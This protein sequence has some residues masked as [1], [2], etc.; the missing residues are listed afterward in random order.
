VTARRWPARLALVTIGLLGAFLAGEALVRMLAPQP[1]RPA[2]SDEVDGIR[3]A[4]PSVRG[5]HAH[6][7]AFDV[8]V[9]I[10][11]QRLR[12]RR[13]YSARPPEGTT[14]LAVLGDSMAF[15][16]G[17]EDDETYP[18]RLEGILARR[19]AVEVVN[20]GFP[21]TCLGEKVG[22]YQAGVR[23]LRPRVVLLTLLGDDV[24]GDL[25][26][27]VFRLENGGLVRSRRS[28]PA[29]TRAR[30]TAAALSR[31]PG[32]RL[33]AEHSQLFM[34]VRRGLT[35][36]LSR[37]RTTALGQ[38]PATAEEARRFREEGIPLLRAELRHLQE[39]LRADGAA[40]A[41]VFVPFRQEVYP[42]PADWW[43]EE[44]R[45]KSRAI[46]EAA[47]GT[48]AAIGAP[49]LDLAPALTRRAAAGPPLYHSGAE[50]HPTPAGYAAIAEEVAEWLE[51]TGLLSGP[52]PP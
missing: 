12:G 27:Q 30:A 4:R 46:V 3:V 16:W 31:A 47:A 48:A 14:R 9:T 11:G 49:F 10:N 7:G 19:R 33:L 6:E 36:A 15:G 23:P 5:R 38:R 18:A 34:V 45:W 32:A 50:T 13:E 25:Y 37:E 51:Q 43:A 22:W 35:R 21:G 39:G 29:T 1:L 44:L 24:D 2:W 40:L 17:A 20:A 26:W 28:A 52:P 41:V 42:G 8:T